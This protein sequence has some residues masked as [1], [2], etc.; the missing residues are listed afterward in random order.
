MA[1]SDRLTVQQEKFVQLVALEGLS[2]TEAYKRTYNCIAASPADITSRASTLAAVPKVASAIASARGAAAAAAAKKAAYTLAHA[3]EEAE[4]AR[5]MAEEKNDAKGV[6]TAVALKAK[7]AG[8][9]VERKEIK[10]GSLEQEDVEVLEA[11]QAE[12]RAR[13]AAKG[14]EVAPEDHN[15]PVLN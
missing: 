11:M 14:R 13:L 7:L 5:K 3:I 2:Q 8:H 1:V 10:F 12:L 6:A 9:M 15:R 4:A